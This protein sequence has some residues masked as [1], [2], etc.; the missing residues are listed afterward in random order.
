MGFFGFYVTFKTYLL[1]I[2]LGYVRSQKE[3]LFKILRIENNVSV[4]AQ[5]KWG[6]SLCFY[7]KLR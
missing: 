1:C 6:I 5:I 7:N 3:P 4:R 2:S